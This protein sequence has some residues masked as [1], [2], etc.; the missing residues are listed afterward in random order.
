MWLWLIQKTY[1]HTWDTC[2]Y[3]SD[4]CSQT[5][6][7][8]KYQ[9]D[10]R[11][12]LAGGYDYIYTCLFCTNLFLF[13]YKHVSHLCIYKQKSG[14]HS[15]EICVKFAW[16]SRETRAI[17]V[18]WNSVKFARVLKFSEIREFHWNS[19]EARAIYVTFYVYLRDSSVYTSKYQAG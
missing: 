13:I 4:L 5:H 12:E 10:I 18:S 14:S 9:G 3:V 15:S 11:V 2:I 1:T 7:T 16:N 8:S 19:L 6:C 17:Y